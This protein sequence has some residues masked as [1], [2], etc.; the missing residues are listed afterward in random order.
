MIL[1]VSE[2][3]Q[4]LHKKMEIKKGASR[5]KSFTFLRL[6]KRK[7]EKNTTTTISNFISIIALTGL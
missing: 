4:W 6:Q 3:E 5:S 2:E 7:K 1:N